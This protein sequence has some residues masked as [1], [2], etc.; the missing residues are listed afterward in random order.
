M[1]DLNQETSN[2]EYYKILGLEKDCT[3]QEIKKQY[4]KMALKWHPV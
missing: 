2:D 4:Y 3:P 1:K